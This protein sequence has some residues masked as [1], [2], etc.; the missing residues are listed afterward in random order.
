[1][2]IKAN[3][4]A[5]LLIFL[6]YLFVISTKAKFTKEQLDD[7]INEKIKIEKSLNQ[8]KL[9]N[10]LTKLMMRNDN[11]ID[12][13]MY[14]LENEDFNFGNEDINYSSMQIRDDDNEFKARIFGLKWALSN[15]REK[16]LKPYHVKEGNEKIENWKN[17]LVLMMGR[18]DNFILKKVCFPDRQGENFGIVTDFTKNC[19]DKVE[20][21]YLIR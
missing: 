9:S 12:K 2:F 3:E 14:F 21:N 7:F 18:N 8:Q 5:S 6:F 20:K 1:M 11:I 10:Y 19:K 13:D 4:K 15:A 16:E 17:Y